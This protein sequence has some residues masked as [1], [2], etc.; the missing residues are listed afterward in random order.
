MKTPSRNLLEESAKILRGELI[1]EATYTITV[2]DAYYIKGNSLSKAMKNGD[3]EDVDMNDADGEITFTAGSP[4]EAQ[5]NAEKAIKDF[6]NKSVRNDRGAV[7]QF[8]D[9]ELG[10]VDD[11][12]P[13]STQ[14]NMLK[15]V[16]DKF[17]GKPIF[18]TSNGRGPAN[19]EKFIR[20]EGIDDGL[21]DGA[22]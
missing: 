12:L 22:M 14:K 4:S 5:R 19:I 7:I 9:I 18:N 16:I 3:A 8:N 10:L 17:D 15:R 13:S 11:N 6:I 20:D 2:N 1:S 21:R